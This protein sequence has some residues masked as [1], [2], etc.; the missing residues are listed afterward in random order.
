MRKSYLPLVLIIMLAAILY[1]SVIAVLVFN[2]QPPLTSN[3]NSNKT[4]TVNIVLYE[5]E[6]APTKY[7][8]GNSSNLLT[9]PGP[10]IRFNMSDV[11]NITVINV[12]SMPHA[13]EI[14]NAPKTGSTMLFNA[15]IGASSYLEPGQKGTVIFTPNNAGSFYYICPV[16]GHAE[17][18]MYGSVV[19]TG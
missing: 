13:F 1:F 17:L 5:G 6:I 12:G 10:T 3:S 9:S 16:P 7:G 18:G 19:I 2:V 11:V 14:T 4:P 15:E 8:F